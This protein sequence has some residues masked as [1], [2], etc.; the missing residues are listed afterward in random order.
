MAHAQAMDPRTWLREG[1]PGLGLIDEDV[2]LLRGSV[3]DILAQ[4]IIGSIRILRISCNFFFRSP[5]PK[6]P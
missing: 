2:D 6:K 5:S 3:C 1:V 4:G